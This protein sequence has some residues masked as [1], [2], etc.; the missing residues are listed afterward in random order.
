MFESGNE[1]SYDGESKQ[2]GGGRAAR[3]WWIS[4]TV[5]VVFSKDSRLEAAALTK[6]SLGGGVIW[7][8]E[9]GRALSVL[10][11]G[12]IRAS[13]ASFRLWANSVRWEEAVFRSH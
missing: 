13:Q 4:S 2:R 6:N 11:F 7:S 3:M 12:I 1:P 8:R 9:M 5:D 10:T